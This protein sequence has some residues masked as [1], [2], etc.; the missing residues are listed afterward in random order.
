MVENLKKLRNK[1]GISQQ[2]LAN[3]F[4]ISQQS[5]NK[6]ENHSIEPDIDTLMRLADFFGTSVDYLIGH[7]EIDRVIEPVQS[8]DLNTDEADLV[9]TYRKLCKPE[10]ESIRLVMRN[11]TEKE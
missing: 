11:Y 3:I 1:K 7:T 8:Y 5:V 4:G 2:M 9:N 6:Y 10:K